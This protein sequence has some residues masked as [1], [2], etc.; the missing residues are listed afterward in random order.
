[1]GIS[2]SKQF[3]KLYK[4]LPKKIQ[5]AFDKRLEIFF[6][7]Q[8]HPILTMHKL[9]GKYRSLYSINVTADIRAVFDKI[10]AN[11]IEFVAIGS[12]SELYS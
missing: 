9:H 7:N 2:Y 1:M 11:E 6:E 10:S 12:H 4:K 5:I 8:K 3:K